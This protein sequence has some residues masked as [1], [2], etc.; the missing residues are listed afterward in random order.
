VKGRRL[1]WLGSSCVSGLYESGETEQEYN[2]LGIYII[3]MIKPERPTDIIL[4]I[5]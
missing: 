1:N 5:T 4:E 2:V 3:L